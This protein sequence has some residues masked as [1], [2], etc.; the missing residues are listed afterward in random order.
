MKLYGSSC[1]AVGQGG[2]A[3]SGSDVPD[4]IKVGHGRVG[5]VMR[6]SA[7]AAGAVRKTGLMAGSSIRALLVAADP[8]LRTRSAE[9]LREHGHT[10]EEAAAGGSTPDV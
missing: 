1:R 9:V 2:I 8:P 3:V 7:C 5:I 6:P 4:V 10:V